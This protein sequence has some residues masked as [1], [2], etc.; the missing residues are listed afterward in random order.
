MIEIEFKKLIGTHEGQV[1]FNRGGK[2][3][4]QKR[5]LGKKPSGNTG[6][7]KIDK[8]PDHIKNE[9]LDL[10]NRNFS[11]VDLKGSI[12]TCINNDLLTGKISPDTLRSLIKDKIVSEPSDLKMISRDKPKPT[13]DN[14]PDS[15]LINQ[16]YDLK[17][18]SQGLTNW[19]KTH[20]VSG[21]ATRKTMEQ[22]RQEVD[23]KWKSNWDKINKENAKLSVEIQEIRDKL[24]ATEKADKSRQLVREKLRADLRAC[25]AELGQ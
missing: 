21:R 7:G 19:A 15:D 18:T 9:I 24:E 2:V 3:V 6:K 1:R 4:T 8:L 17:L 13:I 16:S 25:Q 14:I 20:G 12:E 22:V 23:D 10:R 5:R 11:G